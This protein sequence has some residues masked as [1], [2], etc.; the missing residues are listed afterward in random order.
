MQEVC[1]FVSGEGT[2]FGDLPGGQVSVI[3]PVAGSDLARCTP[4]LERMREQL[5]Q[6]STQIET[7]IVEICK[8]FQDI[9]ERSRKN[10]LRVSGM[11]GHNAN[12]S[13]DD[14]SFESLLQACAG[15]MLKLLDASAA[16]GQVARGAVERIQGIQSA[17]RQITNAIGMLDSIANAN[18]ILALNARIEAAHSDTHGAG[19]AAVAKEL[20]LH[21]DRSREVT[22]QLGE[23]TDGLRTLAN[24]TATDLQQMQIEDDKRARQCRSEVDMTLVELRVAHGDMEQMLHATTAE[25]KLLASDIGAAVRG[26]QFQDRVSQRIAHVVEDLGVVRDRIASHFGNEMSLP[27][28]ADKGFS[29]QSM[30]EERAIYGV[31]GDEST[32]GDV[33]LF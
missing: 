21:T 6:T 27:A 26:L 15:T 24:S 31:V 9:A 25:G 8:S 12:A 2:V 17:A 10:S 1:A 33:E 22:A 11:L 30:P 16:S 23:L 4:Q 20:S 3:D 32:A 28:G 5:V 13:A 7:S 14:R 18:K 19:F 29:R